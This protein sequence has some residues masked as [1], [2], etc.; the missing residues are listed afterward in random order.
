MK[1]I[2]IFFIFAALGIASEAE[3]A[4][5]LNFFA[6]GTEVDITPGTAGSWQDVALT[7]AMGVPA[8]AT[9]VI[10]RVY[11]TSATNRPAYRL[12]K[13][14]S[15]DN[16]PY[17]AVI[18]GGHLGAFVGL[19][20]LRRFQAYIE[21]LDLRIYLVGY[22]D[23]AAYFF[24]NYQP[25]DVPPAAAHW[26]EDKNLSPYI[27]TEATGVIVLLY[28]E[29][30]ASTQAAGVR[31]KGS[32]DGD[33]S[34]AT[35]QA[36]LTN[37]QSVWMASGVDAN[38]LIQTTRSVN[39]GIYLVGYFMPPMV[40]ETNPVA[41]TFAM[42]SW[43]T[44][45][46][47]G[48]NVPSDYSGVLWVLSNQVYNSAG[49]VRGIGGGESYGNLTKNG[50]RMFGTAV[51]ASKQ[52]GAKREYRTDG[53][54]V[55]LYAVGY[56]SSVSLPDTTLPSIPGNLRA[57]VISSSQVDL[58][59]DASTDNV[60]VAGYRIY[61]NGTQI[62][63]SILPNYNNTGLTSN[64]TYTYTVLAFDAAGN[65]SAQSAPVSVTTSPSLDATPPVISSVQATNITTNSA[66]ISWT[67]DDLSTSI[68]NYGTT[69]SLGLTTSN[70]NLFASHSI[71]LT[72]LSSNTTYYYQVRSCNSDNYCANSSTITF[73]TLTPATGSLSITT[74]PLLRSISVYAGYDQAKTVQSSTLTWKKSSESNWNTG[75]TPHDDGNNTLISFVYDYNQANLGTLPNT[76][77]DVRVDVTYTDN[78]TAYGTASATTLPSL[79]PGGTSG[80]V[81]VRKNGNDTTGNGSTG[82]PYRTPQKAISVATAGQKIRIGPGTWEVGIGGPDGPVLNT[83]WRPGTANA[84]IYIESEDVNNKA[85]LITG[86]GAPD[87]AIMFAWS[88]YWVIRNLRFQDSQG[89]MIAIFGYGNNPLTVSVWVVDNYFRR[90][91]KVPGAAYGA[92]NAVRTSG[93]TFGQ[94][95]FIGNT[96]D[97]EGV[98][99]NNLTSYSPGAIYFWGG[100]L[101][102]GNYSVVDNTF[103]FK[104][105]DHKL[106]SVSTGRE[107]LTFEGWVR[108]GEYTGN[109]VD[110]SPDD[111]MQVEGGSYNIRVW[112]NLMYNSFRDFGVRVMNGP[113]WIFRNRSYSD[114]TQ[115]S[116]H[117]LLFSGVEGAI[118]SA[119]LKIGNWFPSDG[120]VYF[121]NNTYFNE[122]LSSSP[123][124]GPGEGESVIFRNGPDNQA[125]P[126]TVAKN[127]LLRAPGSIGWTFPGVDPQ[128]WDY[129]A[130]YTEILRGYW[131][132]TRLGNRPTTFNSWR[133]LPE[134]QQEDNGISLGSPNILID[135]ANF[136]FRPAVNSPI[137]NIGVYI[138]G[139]TENYNGSAPDIGAVEYGVAAP[140]STPPVRSNIS[141]A[142]ILAPGTIQATLSL[143][144]NE[145][146][147]C[148][149]STTAGTSYSSMT[150]NFSTGNGTSHSVL[151]ANLTDGNTYNYYVR[152]QDT[153]S[154][155]N[156]TDSLITFS[157]TVLGDISSQTP[158]VRDGKVNIYDVS[159]MLSKWGSTL[160]ADLAE[161]DINAGPGNI[162]QGRIDLYDANKMMVNWRP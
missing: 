61:R 34:R 100:G 134:V 16:F 147:G 98:Q 96:F 87:G 92:P 131:G 1:Y 35:T 48:P 55:A 107:G 153:A 70:S 140:D 40:F 36:E 4:N 44:V 43:Q 6:N 18:S 144:T 86:S 108:D 156:T 148:R 112:N 65:N 9:G 64:T 74:V 127:N 11:N 111:G 152:C 102:Y 81:F 50:S 138:P 5:G 24:D 26:W 39:G 149:Y 155:P 13:K 14:G 59:W 113:T 71:N 157:V 53:A 136:D 132:W 129:N 52:A 142:G 137:I 89:T 78:S 51:N 25:I 66:T 73:T 150:N 76:S 72:S 67:T 105:S 31:K 95:R 104:D 49:G 124:E 93:N 117:W 79:P 68:V 120:T 57:T 84:H 85:V 37:W 91:G 32:T 33:S 99:D 103:L 145:S 22:T 62:A 121:Y 159:R 38:R 135:P 106:D 162:S 128:L 160:P 30:G 88:S 28:D 125:Y 130:Y 115:Y 94:L 122:S 2:F 101:T 23:Q 7:D 3:A 15:S 90:W 158:G 75:V 56:A 154:N 82:N 10:L 42:G 8:G 41:V 21:S 46:V 77:Y 29:A 119:W 45:T 141:P 118:Q 133:I 12:R 109:Y 54:T 97:M 123:S 27:P 110:N 69:V 47:S 151:V 116:R 83:Q 60:A 143:T 58:A 146:A 63:T 126:N 80:D 17:N 139:I 114:S 20:S 161:V 19:D